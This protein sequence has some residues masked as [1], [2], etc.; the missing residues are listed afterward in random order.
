M[1]VSTTGIDIST[2]MGTSSSSSSS[3]SLDSIYSNLGQQKMNVS[4]SYYNLLK[5]YYASGVS[6]SSTSTSA[7]STSLATRI[8]SSSDDLS[9]AASALRSSS[10][11]TKKS[12]TADDGTVTEEY[13][14]DTLYKKVKDFVDSY[15]DV[16]DNTAD[17]NTTGVLSSASK[18]TKN[19]AANESL[20]SS[21]G[22]SIGSDNKLSI[23]E[24]TFKNSNVSSIKSIF[25][26]TGGYGYQTGVS[27]SMIKSS[28][29][30]EM[31]KSATYTSSGTYSDNYASSYS[32]YV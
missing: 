4:G 2:L 24:E 5:N 20:L 26:S 28:E 7:D 32:D 19:T 3:S 13:D 8:E 10:L 11:Y 27:A 29:E 18:M 15:N 14:M 21:I 1:T 31:N 6:D 12:V 23:D 17:S 16:V 30:T 25:G 9:D 22:I